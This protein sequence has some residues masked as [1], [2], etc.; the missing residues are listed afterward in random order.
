MVTATKLSGKTIWVTRPAQQAG[1]LCRMIAQRQGAPVLLPTLVIRP[2]SADVCSDENRQ[3]L[4]RADIIIFISKN[5][6]VHA[7]DLFP[8][9]VDMLRDKTA[10]AVGQATARC[11]SELGLSGLGL[12]QVGSGGSDA[13]LQLPV[14][15]AE[16]V[17]GKRVVIVRG[18][19]GRETLR[20]T[21]LARGAEVSYL[22]VYR[23]EK[24]TI[25]QADMNKFWHD[26][27]P[28]IVIITS[29]AG[30]DNLV[31]LTPDEQGE[32]LL[33]TGLVV[34]SDRICQQAI[35][36]GFRRIAVATDNT[37]AGLVDALLN[38]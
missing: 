9:L 7:C 32:R 36:S 14:L 5:A 38:I 29:L 12:A 20:T 27:T 28:D 37:D 8:N 11:L 1:E 30:L 6:V 19:G 16:Q 25:S 23:R 13:L 21:L 17:R 10:L 24:P 34:M 35:Q 26:Q 3:R 22:E 2:V 4:A 15:S 18:Q 33:E 31:E